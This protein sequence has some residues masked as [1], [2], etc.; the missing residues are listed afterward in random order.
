MYSSSLTAVRVP[1]GH[2]ADILR[3]IIL[4]RFDMSLGNGLGRL[5][6]SVFR[7]GHLGA[8]NDLMPAGTLSG[9]EMG[10][11]LAGVP[12]SRGRA[13][14]ALAYLAGEAA[15]P[16]GVPATPAADPA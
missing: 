9:V 1:E 12:H 2:S 5:A 15:R 3:R 14:A 16:G 10:L 13:G 4:D 11:E 8:F 6:D 7:I